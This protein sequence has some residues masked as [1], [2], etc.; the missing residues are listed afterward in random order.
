MT[1]RKSKKKIL[2][3]P[4]P[5]YRDRLQF[6]FR[7]LDRNHS[8]FPLKDCSQDFFIAL[9]DKLKEYSEYTEVQFTDENHK[10]RRHKNFWENTSE[11]D[12]FRH[13]DEEVNAEY[14]W[15]FGLDSRDGQRFDRSK[16]WRVHGMLAENIFFVIWLD[17]N[18]KLEAKKSRDAQASQ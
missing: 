2:V 12:G 17:T 10:E 15:Q 14:G 6:S 5:T 7:Y 3:K 11:P 18:H 16:D 8:K 1:K 4:V 13:L 9:L